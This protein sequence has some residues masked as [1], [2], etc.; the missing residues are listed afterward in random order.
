[1]VL[2]NRRILKL[3]VA[4]AFSFAAAIAG[5]SVLAGDGVSAREFTFDPALNSVRMLMRDKRYDEAKVPLDAY[6]KKVPNS[7]LALVYRSRCYIDESNYPQAIGCLKAAQRIDP[8]NSEVYAGLAEIHATLKQ[9]DKAIVAATL[10]IKYR[11]AH[12]NKQMFHLRSMMYSAVGEYEKAIEDMNAYIKI[13]PAKHRAYMWRGTAYEQDGQL[14]KA[15]VDYEYGLKISRNYEYRFHIAR[16]LQKTGRMKDAIAQMTA[17]IKENP[18]EDEGWNKR[19]TLYFESGKYKE[20][21]SDYTN[22]LANNFGS[23]ETLYR[24]RARAYEKLGKRDLAQNDLKKAEEQRK[25][26]TVAPI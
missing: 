22:A 17:L 20:A 19:A 21:V 11:K 1:M 26:P 25:K 10:S 9:Y 16:I 13:D 2:T 8:K 12:Q 15:L 5:N 23:A 7:T 14:D 3:T 6:L 24:A 4:S 18:A